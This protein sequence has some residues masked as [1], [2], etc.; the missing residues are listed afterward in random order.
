MQIEEESGRWSLPHYS[1][2]VLTDEQKERVRKI[3]EEF[4]YKRSPGYKQL[5]WENMLNRMEAKRVSKNN[6]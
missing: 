2:P 5:L 6:E 3:D 4:E 1:V